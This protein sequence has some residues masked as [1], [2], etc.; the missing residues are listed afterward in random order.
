MSKEMGRC[1]LED[2]ESPIRYYAF[3]KRG[4]MALPLCKEHAIWL[5][6]NQRLQFGIQGSLR[7]ADPDNPLDAIEGDLGPIVVVWNALEGE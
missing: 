3:H 1:V 5:L 6:V 4:V 2:C 7:I